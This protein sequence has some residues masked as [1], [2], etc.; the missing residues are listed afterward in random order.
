MAQSNGSGIT[1][2]SVFSPSTGTSTIP[3]TASSFFQSAVQSSMYANMWFNPPPPEMTSLGGVGHGGQNMPPATTT[4]SA[5]PFMFPNMDLLSQAA[6]S[7]YNQSQT[8]L[9]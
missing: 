5:A 3:T 2:S 8:V 6:Q 4:S 7:M 9:Q 1:A